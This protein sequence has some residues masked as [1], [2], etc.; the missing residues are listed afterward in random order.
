MGHDQAVKFDFQF[1]ITQGGNLSELEMLRK[2]VRQLERA[3]ET[4]KHGL[5]QLRV[6][7]ARMVFKQMRKEGEACL[8]GVVSIRNGQL[9]ENHQPV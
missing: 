1:K 9:T 7:A 4:L 6:D 5:K 8:Q 3:N 2:K